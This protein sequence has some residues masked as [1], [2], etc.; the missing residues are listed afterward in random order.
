LRL[1][2]R[3]AQSPR[4][5]RS[6]R[7]ACSW[8]ALPA[9]RITSCAAR[10][11]R[12]ATAS[13]GMRGW[14]VSR[15]ARRS[16]QGLCQRPASADRRR[17]GRQTDALL[18]PVRPLVRRACLRRRANLSD[19]RH[20]YRPTAVLAASRRRGNTRTACCGARPAAH[21]AGGPACWSHSCSG[22]QPAVCQCVP[23]RARA[24][25]W[26]TSPRSARHRQLAAHLLDSSAAVHGRQLAMSPTKIKV[27][28]GCRGGD[29]GR[30]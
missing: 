3:R 20:K 28:M 7:K 19:L 9:A 4:R 30:E 12:T 11:A 5:W 22:L 27:Y 15:L 23:W 8:W 21:L 10:R 14:R 25:T 6:A 2:C 17:P 16:S 29:I 1:H 24:R 18:S 13:V 26:L